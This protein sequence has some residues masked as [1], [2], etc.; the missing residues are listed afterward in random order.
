[1]PYLIARALT[2]GRILLDTF[3]DEAARDKK[4]LALLDKI[5]MKVDPKL[6]SGS[7]GSRP[8]TVTI[9]LTSGQT[10]TLH[11]TFPKG[12]PQVPMTPEERLAKFRDCTRPAL[13]NAASERAL[14]YINQ[15]ETMTN[16]RQ[17]AALLGG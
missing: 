11:Q 13:G 8:A 3:T 2:D 1:M 6:V 5:E 10:L 9:R 14:S 7:D 12:S 16:V 15:L 4:V 17:L